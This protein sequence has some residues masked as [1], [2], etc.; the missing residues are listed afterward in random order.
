MDAKKICFIMCVNNEQYMQEAISYINNLEL[1]VGYT[2]EI[3]TV[4]EASGMAAGY[5]EAMRSS[6]AK[7]KVYLHQDV[8]IVEQ[9]FIKYLL[10]LFADP[11]IGLI[12]MV[13]STGLPEN[14]VMWHG[15][16]VGRIYSS[17][18]EKMTDAQLGEVI[19]EYQ[20]VEAVDGLLIATQYDFNWRE[21][22]FHKWDFYDVS[23]SFEFRKK[24]YK[25]IV[26]R[27]EQP[28]CIHDDGFVNLTDYY[29]ERKKF[30]KEYNW[31][32]RKNILLVKTISRYGSTNK[33][34]DEWASALRK[35]GCNTCVLDGW[36]LAQPALYNHVLSNCKF[37]AVFDLNGILCSWGITKKLS[38]ESIYAIYICDPPTSEDLQDKLIQADDR[39]VVFGCDR[40]FCDYIDKYFPMVKHTK[41]VPL[42]GSAYPNC[43]PYDKRAIDILFTGTYTSPEKYKMQAL[44]KFEKGSV[45]AQFTEGMLEDIITNSQLTLPECLARTL[46]K[47]HQ[48]V[49]DSD[50]HEL[51]A[52]FLCIDFYARSY[53]REKVIQT[54]L[55]AGL[56][57]D[58]F[59]NGWENFPSEHKENLVIHKG[60]SYAASKAL[61]NAKI[62]LNIMPWFKD[63][64]QERIAAAMLSHTVAVT[65]ESK[66]IL[67][68]F[69]DGKNLL[70][71]SLKEIDSLPQ[72]IRNL[73][74]HPAE[75]AGI[76]ENGFRKVQ[77]HTWAARVADMVQKVEK[78]FG[79]TLTAEGEGRELEFEIEYPD[80]NNMIN[81][82]VYEL[83]Q[84]AAMAENELG[85][86]EAVSDTDINFL[87]KKFDDFTRKFTGHLHEMEMG[88]YIQKCMNQPKEEMRPH[89]A[90]LFATQCRAL[91]GK[92]LLEE[93]GIKI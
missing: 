9:N 92:L 87:L 60:G 75:A 8:M 47:Y 21:D 4:L 34:I 83:Y 41:F 64:F 51:S 71:F 66:Y 78:D 73:L 91:M 67:E 12:G 55:D 85:Q 90:E 15:S 50:F 7:Y 3:L 6:D 88:K 61:A 28:W 81:D 16:R 52:E 22:V 39:T 10:E 86:M 56:K 27:M 72:R 93:K 58:V 13:G 32:R 23:Q 54:L 2:L 33:Y 1:P 17:N 5:N 77:E 84:M 89:L 26:P 70:V 11:S 79:V 63:G 14:A 82:A 43:V 35:L 65:D 76:A 40:N 46:D 30:I 69:E 44:S 29:E 36:S 19:G 37:D 62:S 31:G 48:K 24:G 25:V 68:N 80:K 74:D 49:S 57:I 59:G 20:E 45:M 38:P 42:S 18:I 53:Y